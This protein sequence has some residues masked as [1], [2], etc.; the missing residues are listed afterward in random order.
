MKTLFKIYN[1]P[2]FYL[3]MMIGVFVGATFDLW[4][5]FVLLFAFL[6]GWAIV[7]QNGGFWNQEE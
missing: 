1:I 5:G 4:P 3:I 6:V 2:A 7:H